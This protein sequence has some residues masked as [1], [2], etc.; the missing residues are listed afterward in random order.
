M[1][2]CFVEDSPVCMYVCFFMSDFWWNRLPACERKKNNRISKFLKKKL[3]E[4][5]SSSSKITAKLAGIWPRIAVNEE[6]R[7]ERTW[8][9]ES[10][11]TLL[12][13]KHFLD[14]VN[15]SDEKR[16]RERERETH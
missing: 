9:L 4:K 8:A 6:M 14:I 12:A 16:E 1:A 3:T 11:A 15:R 10:L 7:R 2:I 13:L 5:V